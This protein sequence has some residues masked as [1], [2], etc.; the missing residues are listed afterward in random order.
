M[1]YGFIVPSITLLRYKKISKSMFLQ[2]ITPNDGKIIKYTETKGQQCN[3]IKVYAQMISD[4]N[5]KCRQQCIR[6]E[7]RNEDRIIKLVWR[8]D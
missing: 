6:E 4:K 5:E 2:K 1:I 8:R 7:A 3:V